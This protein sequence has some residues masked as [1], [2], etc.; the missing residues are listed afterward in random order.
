MR[1][2]LLAFLLVA[3][4][5]AQ[6]P[7]PSS[8][9]A[10]PSSA[11]TDTPA[12]PLDALIADPPFGVPAGGRRPGSPG[13]TGPLELRSIVFAD[14][15]Y[16]FS[17][18][19]QGTGKADW[20]KIGETGFP[21]VARSFNRERD[22]L[23]VEHQ[24]RTLVLA[25]QPAKTAAA[26]P[27]SPSGGPSPLPTA[28]NRNGPLPPSPGGSNN[29]GPANNGAPANANAS[30]GS[31]PPAATSNPNAS[32]A[33]RLQNLADEIRRRRGTGPQLVLPK[34]QP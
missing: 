24:G 5:A 13:P 31:T 4:M 18:Y 19:D 16:Q 10:T 15:A 9:P 11:A 2:G 1:S 20:V 32:E 3:A 30:A 17:I 27:N 29:S 33:Q 14:G 22:S 23:T 25:L 26:A 8:A 7:A 6:A 34:N 28:N 21:F 12:D